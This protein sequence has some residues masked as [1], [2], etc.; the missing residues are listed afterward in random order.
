MEPEAI[1]HGPESPGTS[2]DT[3][4]RQTKCKSPE[5]AG[6]PRGPLGKGLRCRGQL[7]DPACPQTRT[8]G[9]WDTWLNMLALGPGAESPGRAGP[10]RG[11]SDPGLN[12]RDA[13]STP[14]YVRPGPESPR[15]AG[16]HRGTSD[17]GPSLP[18]QLVNNTGP[19]TQAR[20]A[21]ESW[22]TLRGLGNGLEMPRKLID[23]PGPWARAQ[24][25]RDACSTLR[26]LRPGPES[27]GRA[28]RHSGTSGTGLSPL[29]VLVDTRGPRP[30]S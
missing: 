3:G 22:S 27:P 20:V 15:T 17:T 10:T 14:R 12:P 2:G 8:Q 19:Q 4:S 7:A 23:N 25:A 26:S 29:G 13:W 18:G 30:M 5:T 28:G 24:V 21:Q 6:R 11:H 1:R 9:T 16:R